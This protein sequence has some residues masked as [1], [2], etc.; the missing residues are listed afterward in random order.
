MVFETFVMI[1]YALGT[2]VLIYS[3]IV[4]IKRREYENK[5]ILSGFNA[6][7]FGI[8]LLALSFFLKMV[9]NIVLI[10]WDNFDWLIYLDI[11]SNLILM[12]LFGISFLVAMFL[13]KEV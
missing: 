10:F 6:L 5:R 4:L 11:I 1:M 13:F 7:I 3:G 2:I 8:F 12:P 9:L